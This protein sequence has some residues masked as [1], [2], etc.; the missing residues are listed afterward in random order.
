[1]QNSDYVGGATRAGRDISSTR[2]HVALLFYALRRLPAVHVVLLQ[3]ARHVV[4]SLE[5]LVL[6]DGPDGAVSY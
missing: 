4:F 6:L 2:A 1:M 5:E 3:S